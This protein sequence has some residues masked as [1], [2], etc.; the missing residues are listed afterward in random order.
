MIAAAAAPLAAQFALPPAVGFKRQEEE[1]MSLLQAGRRQRAGC[2][3]WL[4]GPGEW[5]VWCARW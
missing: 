2:G 4:H 5:G 1:L 3:L